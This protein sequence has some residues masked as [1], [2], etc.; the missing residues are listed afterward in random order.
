VE[1]RHLGL[2][3]VIDLAGKTLERQQFGEGNEIAMRVDALFLQVGGTDLRRLRN[4]IPEIRR[5]AAL[6]QRGQHHA[7]R[8]GAV[9]HREVLAL[10]IG[11]LV[12]R[13]VLVDDD[14]VAAAEGVI[15]D[16][17]DQLV[18]FP[19]SSTRAFSASVSPRNNGG[20]PLRCVPPSVISRAPNWGSP[21]RFSPAVDVCCAG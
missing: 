8:G 9:R 15:G 19:D 2:G 13:R 16:D 12:E 5:Q 21:D 4:Q 7:V 17:G 1:G 3:A 18:R 14:A 6:L 11:E 20:G 10:E